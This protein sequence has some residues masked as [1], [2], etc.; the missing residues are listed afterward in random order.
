MSVTRYSRQHSHARC[1]AGKVS[2]DFVY[3]AGGIA[4]PYLP[5][6]PSPMP[7]A[8]V[9]WLMQGRKDNM[10]SQL[11]CRVYDG[12]AVRIFL[13]WKCDSVP[14]IGV[15]GLYAY[16]GYMRKNRGT[17]MTA[18]T[19]W[20]VI[21]WK[22]TDFPL[23]YYQ[24]SLH[25][26]WDSLY[27]AWRLGRGRCLLLNISGSGVGGHVGFF[28]RR[29]FVYFSLW[30]QFG[31]NV[32]IND[33][34]P[35]DVG[36]LRSIWEEHSM[37]TKEFSGLTSVTKQMDQ[38]PVNIDIHRFINTMTNILLYGEKNM[39]Y[40]KIW[41]KTSGRDREMASLSWV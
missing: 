33:I 5:L 1:S 12:A 24:Y 28:P 8:A 14:G 25:T 20:N 18:T 4:S 9:T 13:Y 32:N 40:D 16:A 26:A 35:S 38:R 36:T 11:Q 39:M 19:K 37:L 23:Q 17:A 22:L 34:R 3:S 21:S 30:R 10:P 6:S 2:D 29:Q 41:R 15:C 7:P 31:S 27:A